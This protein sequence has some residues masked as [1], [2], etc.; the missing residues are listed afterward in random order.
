MIHAGAV[1][2]VLIIGVLSVV[3]GVVVLFPVAAVRGGG[4]GK[5]T[6][7][8]CLGAKSH[9]SA[10]GLLYI[11]PPANPQGPSIQVQ[12]VCYGASFKFLMHLYQFSICEV[13]WLE[14]W[15]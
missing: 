13:L 6:L 10:K 15:S 11:S 14:V 7:W 5:G 4:M 9:L 12:G 1:G 3:V 8:G 2:L